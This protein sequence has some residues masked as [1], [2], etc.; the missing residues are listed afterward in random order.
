MG[1]PIINREEQNWISQVIHY[2]K[3]HGIFEYLLNHKWDLWNLWATTGP[4]LGAC[5]ELWFL[6]R[7]GHSSLRCMSSR[8]LLPLLHLWFDSWQTLAE[9]GGRWLEG[10]RK[11]TQIKPEIQTP[12]NKKRTV[13]WSSY[14]I[15]WIIVI[16]SHPSHVFESLQ[17]ACK[18]PWTAC[19]H[20]L[21][22]PIPPRTGWIQFNLTVA[23]VIL[24]GGEWSQSIWIEVVERISMHP[25]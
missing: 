19:A 11:Q 10:P 5:W 18:S 8:W 4:P 21:V 3:Y 25:D 6:H 17:F 7:L 16:I 22:S 24:L 23:H 13:P 15:Y 20:G 2:H 12:E 1:P 14:M 9:N